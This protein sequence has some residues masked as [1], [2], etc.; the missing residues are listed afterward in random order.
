VA[1]LIGEFVAADLLRTRRGAVAIRDP[2]RLRRVVSP[3]PQ[4]K[5]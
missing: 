5:G 2:Y 1:R 3:D 4:R